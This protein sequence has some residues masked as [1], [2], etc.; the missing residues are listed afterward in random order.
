[1]ITRSPRSAADLVRDAE[2]LEHVERA[3]HDVEIGV[4]AHDHAHERGGSAHRFD[5]TLRVCEP[6]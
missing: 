3:L 5:V 4:A 2:L 6:D 1:M